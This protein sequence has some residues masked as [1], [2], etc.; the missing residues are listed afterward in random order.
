MAAGYDVTGCL[1]PE[2][3][4]L[5]MTSPA[6]WLLSGYGCDVTGC[7]APDWLQLTVT[8]PEWLQLIVTSPA[9]WRLIG[10]SWGVVV[11][12]AA[13]RRPV[14]NSY[15]GARSERVGSNGTP[16]RAPGR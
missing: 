13:R 3:L 14:L 6:V 16:R 4:P 12:S 15:R 7:L 2:W 8:S 11:V 10:C 1:A 5:I 9:I